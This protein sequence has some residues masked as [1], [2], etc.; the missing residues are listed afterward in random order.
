V[1]APNGPIWYFNRLE[2]WYPQ[3]TNG[4]PDTV[5]WREHGDWLQFWAHYARDRSPLPWRGGHQW[6]WELVQFTHTLCALSQHGRA[7][8]TSIRELRTIDDRPCIWVALGKHSNWAQPG[9]HHTHGIDFDIARGDGRILSHYRLEPAPPD[10]WASHTFGTITAP[11]RTLAWRDP[12]AWA[13]RV[14]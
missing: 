6:D 2:R 14:A 10:G 9:I 13:A 11:G 1:S 12:A 3:S 4:E 8:L 5:F 7:H